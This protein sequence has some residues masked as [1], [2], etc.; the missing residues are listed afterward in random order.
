MKVTRNENFDF[1]EFSEQELA[2]LGDAINS[3]RKIGENNEGKGVYIVSKDTITTL[4][5]K[6]GFGATFDS[7]VSKDKDDDTSR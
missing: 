1:V 3:M 2:Q 4:L 6:Y 7:R 5:V